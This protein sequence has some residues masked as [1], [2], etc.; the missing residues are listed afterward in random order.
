MAVR[1]PASSDGSRP[2]HE[3]PAHLMA[4]TPQLPTEP[5]SERCC[6]CH[7][8]GRQPRHALHQH[9]PSTHA[10]GGRGQ[11]QCA[12]ALQLPPSDEH[13]AC[14]PL[15]RHSQHDPHPCH[16][17][18]LHCEAGSRHR[19]QGGPDAHCAA[20]TAASRRRCVSTRPRAGGRVRHEGCGC[21]CTGS[22]RRS[23][24]GR[25]LLG[26]T[27]TATDEPKTSQSR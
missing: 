8:Q 21:A 11:T 12:T 1:Y 18:H 22:S 9:L 13:Q 14:T 17:S 10:A 24:D 19:R 15:P 4:T 5:T 6:S 3:C 27:A 26:D 20:A 16:S 23:S 2:E 25:V 7:R